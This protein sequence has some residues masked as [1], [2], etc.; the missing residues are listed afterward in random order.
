MCSVAFVS[1]IRSVWTTERA[2]NNVAN[3]GQMLW[4]SYTKMSRRCSP[5]MACWAFFYFNKRDKINTVVSWTKDAHNRSPLHLLP[6]LGKK[7]STSII[8]RMTKGFKNK[9]DKLNIHLWRILRTHEM[10][11]DLVLIETNWPGAAFRHSVS[12]TKYSCS[13][14][15]FQLSSTCSVRNTRLFARISN[16]SIRWP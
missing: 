7:F 4:G 3:G 9:T 12:D 2:V 15:A 13:L 11:L 5:M 16:E 6:N 1:L 8:Q 10:V 14:L